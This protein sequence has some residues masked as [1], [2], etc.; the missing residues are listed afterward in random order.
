M[1]WWRIKIVNRHI[2]FLCKLVSLQRER[3]E[4]ILAAEG[5]KQAALSCAEQ[6]RTALAERLSGLQQQL[7]TCETE[8][9]RTRREAAARQQRDE[10]AQA[11]LGNELKDFRRQ[12]E[13]TC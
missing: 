12:Y 4:A 8:L 5:D 13:E 7:R 6:E 11:E 10:T 1:A 9:E 2:L 3:D